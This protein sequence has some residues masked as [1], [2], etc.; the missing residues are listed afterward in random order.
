MQKK[1]DMTT[2]NKS[3]NKEIEGFINIVSRRENPQDHLLLGSNKH[4][5][6]NTFPGY[7]FSCNKFGHKAVDCRLDMRRNTFMSQNLFAPLADF[8]IVCYK[9][10]NLGHIEIFCRSGIKSPKQDK[11]MN[12]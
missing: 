8:T 11:K 4:S 1:E 10:N 2:K 3:E 9:C 7:Y 12:T 5:C 6:S